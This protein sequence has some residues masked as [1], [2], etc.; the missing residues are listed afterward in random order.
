MIYLKY[1]KAADLVEVLTGI[2]SS[3]QSDKQSARPVAAIDKNIIIK[4]HGQTNAL[5]VT[6]A[7]DVMNDLERVIAQLDIRRPQVLVE[8]IIAEVQDADGLNLG[9]QWANKNA[10][11]TQFTNSGLPISTAIAGANQYNKDGTISSSLASALGSFNGIAAGFYQ[12][13][14]R[15]CS[16]PLQQYQERYSGH[17]SIVTLDN[18]QATF[19]V[20]QEVPV[21]TGSQTTSGDNIFNTVERKT[22]GIKLK[23]KPQIN[24]GDAVLLEIEQEVSSVA[25]SASSTSSDLGATFN[26]RTVNNA[27]LV[28]SGETVVVGGLLDKTVTDTA[29]KVPLLGDI[30]VI[31]ALFRSDSKKVSK[32]NLMLFIRPTIIRDRDEYRQ[33]LPASTPPSTMRKLNSGVKKAAK[34]RSATTCC[35]SIRSR[36]PRLSARSAP[37][38]TPS[39]SEAAHDASRRTPSAV[40]LR[41]ARAHHLVLLSDGERCEALCR[42]DTAARALLEARR[43]A[44]GPM[45]VSR[46]AP[47]AF[48]K[49]L[50]LSYQRDSAE[51]HRMMADI[52]NE[53]DL[54]TLAEELPDTDDLL[55]SEDD[56]PII[57]LINAMLTE[58]IKEKASDIHIETYER[59]LQIRFRV[60]GVLREILRRSGGWPPC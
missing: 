33:L 53:L 7:P 27:V 31:G 36:R 8:A 47:D 5:I 51:A 44:D 50:V 21:L 42:P 40:A 14:G 48:E 11:M 1:A 4:A 55:D 54:Y 6:A 59:H 9:I 38:L 23:V 19:N 3:L 45:R 18:M 25:D 34:R 10:G 20:G 57:R 37:P 15:C 52:G 46:L 28:G 13:T 60:D 49:V 43:L 56:A 30:P 35:I 16:P 2:S 22:V 58:A 17:P 24:E 29:D 12:G 41:L 26:T 39:I 32:R